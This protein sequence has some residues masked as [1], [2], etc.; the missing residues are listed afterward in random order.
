MRRHKSNHS[1]TSL[2]LT[3]SEA[4]LLSDT[5]T[6][7]VLNQQVESKGDSRNNG[8]SIVSLKRETTGGKQTT[9]EEPALSA[10][11]EGQAHPIAQS[12]KASSKIAA[13]ASKLM[14]KIM[15]HPESRPKQ[16]SSNPNIAC[17]STSNTNPDLSSLTENSQRQGKSTST[18][19]P[20]I[21]LK[22]PKN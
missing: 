3:S 8:Q 9:H 1:V 12:V 22:L 6:R 10:R 13:I 7:E 11:V 18:S 17:D 15:V 2:Q 21:S 5:L 4:K 19:R 20:S 16:Q 14:R